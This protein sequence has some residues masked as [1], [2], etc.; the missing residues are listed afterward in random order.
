MAYRGVEISDQKRGLNLKT[1]KLAAGLEIN[2]EAFTNEDHLLSLL[3]KFEES[4]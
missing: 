4:W 2:L 1:E 3:S